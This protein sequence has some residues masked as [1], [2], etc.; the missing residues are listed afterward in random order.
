MDVILSRRRRG[1]LVATLLIE[2]VRDSSVASLPQND[3]SPGQLYD[4]GLSL[5]LEL[6]VPLGWV[7]P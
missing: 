5:P 6:F 1:V 4:S 3:I 2:H 7:I